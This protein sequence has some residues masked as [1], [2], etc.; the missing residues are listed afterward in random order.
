[1]TVRSLPKTLPKKGKKLPPLENGDRLTRR[2][3]E[4]RYEAMP[5][6]KKAELIE[7]VVYMGSA[8][9]FESHAEPHGMIMTWLGL[10]CS[11]TAGVKLGDNPTV[12]LD[13]DNEVQPDAILFLEERLGGRSR[14]SDDDYIEGTPELIA[15]IAASTASIDLGDKKKVYR[16]QGVCEYIVWQVYENQLECFALQEE[17]YVPL[18]PDAAGIIR[19][20]VFPGL[21]LAA[22]ALLDDDMPLVISVLQ[23]GLQ[24]TEYG[25]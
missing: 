20:E 3:F 6:V 12:R 23:Q 21:W 7:G 13:V 11:F 9:R 22:T 4:R 5:E 24:A 10:Y 1:M 14:I 25:D 15:E 17:E 19:S 2:E 8:P 18:Q 16:R